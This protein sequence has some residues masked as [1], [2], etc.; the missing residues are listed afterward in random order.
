[1]NIEN[2]YVYRVTW[3]EE[4]GEHVGLCAEFPSL[5]HLAKDPVEALRGIRGLVAG[6]VAEMLDGGEQPPEPLGDRKYTGNIRLRVSPSLHRELAIEAQE[7]G[8][9]MNRVLED[10]LLS[11]SRARSMSPADRKLVVL[12]LA[13]RDGWIDDEKARQRLQ[14]WDGWRIR[15]HR[16]FSHAAGSYEVAK[17][18]AENGPPGITVTSRLDRDPRFIRLT[19]DQLEKVMD[20]F[21]D[22]QFDLGGS[23]GQP[24]SRSGRAA[25]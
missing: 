8:K 3:S 22:R 15:I 11:R 16:H 13:L 23:L 17:S 1:M 14:D 7:E 18:M 10:R 25:G 20:A 19:K 5:S 24:T 2:R 6:E 21:R 4:D 9:S 12:N